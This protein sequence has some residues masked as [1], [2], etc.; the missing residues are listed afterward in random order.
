MTVRKNYKSD[1][2]RTVPVKKVIKTLKYKTN[3][4]PYE[5][6]TEIWDDS[7]YGGDGKLETRQAYTPAGAWIGAPKYARFLCRQQRIKPECASKKHTV[8]SIGF[9][10]MDQKWYGW[11][12]RAIFGFGIGDH[13]FEVRYGNDKTLF[14]KHGKKKIKKLADAK[15]AAR[16]F[17]RYVS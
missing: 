11:S 17:A 2:T 1:G 10:E 15:L 14:R 3:T 7:D 16:R 8:C 9:C 4:I 13:I 12:H 5:V 6:R